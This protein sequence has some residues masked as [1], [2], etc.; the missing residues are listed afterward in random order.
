MCTALLGH[1]GIQQIK[2]C[3]LFPVVP[4]L[5]W[6]LFLV[7]DADLPFCDLLLGLLLALL[8]IFFFSG[9]PDFLPG[10]GPEPPLGVGTLSVDLGDSFFFSMDLACHPSLRDSRD[11]SKV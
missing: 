7:P 10:L 5:D 11:F 3:L 4:G 9:S 1:D 8:M 2:H 6:L